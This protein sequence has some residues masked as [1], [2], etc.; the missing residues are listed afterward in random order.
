MPATQ[1][2][3]RRDSFLAL[4]LLCLCGFAL[5]SF[6]P[7]RTGPFLFDDFPNLAPLGLFGGVHDWRS[8]ERFIFGGTSGPL[9]RPLALATFLINDHAWPSDPEPFKYTNL[10]LHLLAG[11]VLFAFLLQLERANPLRRVPP[12]WAAWFATGAWMLSPLQA[13]PIFLTVQRMTILSGLFVFAGLALWTAGRNRI[14]ENRRGGY[15]RMTAGIAGGS[16]LAALCKENGV[17][18]APLAWVVEAT[19][20]PLPRERTARLWK[21]AFLGL[22]SLAIV[23][24]FVVQWP[25]VLNG[26]RWRDFTLSERLMTEPGIL[27]DYLRHIFLPRI[28]TTIF[29]DDY[30]LTV[31]VNAQTVA[32]WLG[33]ILALG[34]A[35]IARRKAPLFSFAVLFFLAGHVLES[36]PIALEL[37]YIHRN[38]VPMVGMLFAVAAAVAILLRHHPRVTFAIAAAYLALLAV[39]TRSESRYWGNEGLLANAWAVERPASPRAASMAANYWSTRGQP[40]KAIALVERTLSLQPDSLS[41]WVG[42]YYLHCL[43]GKENRAIW[44]KIWDELP[45]GSQNFALLG[46]FDTLA[47]NIR[48]H[49]CRE[50]TIRDIAMALDRLKQNPYFASADLQS[51]INYNLAIYFL[52]LNEHAAAAGALEQAIKHAPT[53]YELELL[54]D[55]YAEYGDKQRA[56][57]TYRRALK[58]NF[59]SNVYR[60]FLFDNPE[61]DGLRKKLDGLDPISREHPNEVSALSE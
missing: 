6:W 51:Q 17:L 10:M 56:A 14:A 55:L 32:T 4:G 8:A 54:G 15:L 48:D 47:L 25:E 2:A 28:T 9:G 13:A 30:P 61:T 49:T 24:Y 1:T 7:G 60:R 12:G 16:F 20:A 40:D 38:Y 42:D 50:V 19:L 29:R 44:E 26:Y 21:L 27:I 57:A 36:G 41:L 46:T 22:P 34:A 35:L 59:Y 53:V 5:W 58:I 11:V 43:A 37:Y 45:K 33:W 3:V 18:L 52:E 31:S 23:A 39:L